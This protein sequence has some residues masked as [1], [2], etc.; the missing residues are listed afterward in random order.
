M[1][2]LSI[3]SSVVKVLDATRK[4]VSSGSMSRTVSAKCVASTF[5]TNAVRIERCE[6]GA[7]AIA[8]MQG[9]RSEPPMPMLTTLRTGLPLRPRHAPE[10]TCSA[11]AA[12][13][14]ST[15]RTPGM[16]SLPSP[17][18]IT[19]PPERARSATC[20]TARSSVSLMCSP[21]NIASIFS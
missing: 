19:G 3:V 20:R 6:N 16:T 11:K 13:L 18:S 21:R 9:P 4:S 10:R 14:S 8:A 1:F 15:S 2:A 12:I 7:R 5:E 17:W